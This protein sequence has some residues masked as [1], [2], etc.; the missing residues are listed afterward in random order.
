M[1]RVLFLLLALSVFSLSG[2]EKTPSA[3]QL[4][5]ETISGET[6]GTTW[7]I[8]L[9][10]P[11]G[12]DEMSLR[13]EVQ[14]RL[15]QVVAEMSHWDSDSDLSR[16]NRAAPGTRVVLP[17]G[18]FQVLNHATQL[19]LDTDG[20]YDPSVGALVNLWG[21]GPRGE[22]QQPPDA[23][24]IA[25]ALVHVGSSKLQLDA[26]TRSALQPGGVELDLSS[27]APG[28]AVDQI[29][30]VLNKNGIENF[31][32]ELGGELRA[33]GRRADGKPWQ[34]AIQQP[35]SAD[36]A[37]VDEQDHAAV[38]VL[39]DRAIGAS[40]DYR[41]YFE[42]G[43]V[44]YAHTLDTR[45]GRPVTHA[46]ASAT[47]IAEDCLHA[48]ALAGALMVLGPDAGLRHALEKNIAAL[49]IIRDGDGFIRRETPAFTA[50]RS[51]P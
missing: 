7:S 37:A 27:S 12:S 29:A 47:V 5:G 39:N 43:G 23:A 50:L 33:Q 45:S 21:F 11:A 22:R 9:V 15:D 46:L 42:A 1:V 44:H 18:L 6:M 14:S 17:E 35:P 31:L 49:L 40:G 48:D 13:N 32:I 19:S 4:S 41:A 16:F 24:E 51:S 38:M 2:C 28:F 30:E 25:A 26:G 34:V 3:V 36:E 10:A 20:A 8:V